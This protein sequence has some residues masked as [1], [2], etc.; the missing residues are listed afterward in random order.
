MASDT[1]DGAADAG[2]PYFSVQ[3][4]SRFAPDLSDDYRETADQ[5]LC[6]SIAQSFAEHI[7]EFAQNAGASVVVSVDLSTPP[8]VEVAREGGGSIDVSFFGDEAFDLMFWPA[9]GSTPD[10]DL[11]KLGESWPGLDRSGVGFLSHMFVETGTLDV[12]TA[13]PTEVQ[14]D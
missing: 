14:L 6:E 7:E 13:D 9:V 10:E 12:P 5:A 2:V 3:N 11:L 4:L 1:E 8:S